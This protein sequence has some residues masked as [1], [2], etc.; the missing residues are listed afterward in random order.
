[1]K[2]ACAIVGVGMT[3]FG[4]FPDLTVRHLAEQAARAA[5][6]DAGMQPDDVDEV[7][8]SNAV[9]G[10]ITGQE[11]IRGQAALRFL[12]LRGQAIFNVENACASGSTAFHLAWRAV[13]SGRVQAALVVGAER[14]THADKRVSLAALATAVD[15]DEKQPEHVGAGS[16]SI[17]M[18]IYAA[19]TRKYMAE[20]G[21]TRE[22]LAG[23]V[24][25]SRRA[26]SLNPNAQFR[27]E[28]TVPE[29]LASRV[30]SDPLTLQM[31]SSI[32]DGAAAIVV[33]SPE[34]AAR[35]SARRPVWV[36][37][38]VIASGT[39]DGSS[40][41]AAVRATF[42]AYE[43]AGVDPRDIHVAELHDASAP[44]ELMYYESLGLCGP[45]D[46]PAL[47]RS[48]QTGING[49][50]SVNPS[51]GLLSKGHPIGATGVAQLVEL[52][53]QLRGEA[54]PRQ[55][56]DAKVALAENNGGQVGQDAAVA[57]A[58]ILHV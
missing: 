42:Q 50:I 17:F 31:C 40:K 26:A 58:T 56:D 19:R 8:F 44:A 4:K 11:M 37:G 47:L 28:T 57:A 3:P 49:R 14:M 52:T 54:G 46:G 29:V 39:P 35:L 48:G 22:D 27:A 36:G 20:S 43:E 38:S 5:L 9:G 12:G 34:R 16:G 15:L 32:G 41:P 18:D 7:Y 1:M 53:H 55:R 6:A 33:C 23:I 10:M 25:K 24:V 45:G 21:A 2:Q 30:I 13:S 51:G